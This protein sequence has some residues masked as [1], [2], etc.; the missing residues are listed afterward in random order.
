MQLHLD[1]EPF[2]YE[3]IGML[4][5]SV[6]LLKDRYKL[7]DEK[8]LRSLTGRFQPWKEAGAGSDG[9]ETSTG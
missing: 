3:I 6:D 5:H 1:V 4:D 7:L 8:L 9:K 2:L